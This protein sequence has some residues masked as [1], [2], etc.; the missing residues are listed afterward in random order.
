MITSSPGSSTASAVESTAS[1]TPQQTVISV[2]GSMAIPRKCLVLSAIASRIGLAPQV[3][4]Y[5]LKS[6]RMASTAAS[7]S[8]AG[9]AKS[10][11]PWARLR[12]FSPC[13]ARHIRV[14]SRITDSVNWADFS[15]TKTRA[16]SQNY[17][18]QHSR[19]R[20]SLAAL[21]G[22]S[23]RLTLRTFLESPCDHLIRHCH[24]SECASPVDRLE[25]LNLQGG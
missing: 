8:S 22:S 3:V 5:W 17:T 1:V 23:R 2:S 7:L 25:A 12:Q 24:T 18:D 10:G 15:D 14:I 19:I 6:A 21:A 9:A 4:A 13:R 16:I 20:A 11:N